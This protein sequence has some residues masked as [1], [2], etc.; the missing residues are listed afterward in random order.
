MIL[1]KKKSLEKFKIFLNL[2]VEDNFIYICKVFC[3]KE[4][5]IVW[6]GYGYL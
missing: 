1:L 2:K 6:N 4:I 5:D 3:L